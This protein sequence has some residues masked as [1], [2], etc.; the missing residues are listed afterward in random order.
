MAIG[1]C[2]SYGK[3][4]FHQS[5]TVDTENGAYTILTDDSTRYRQRGEGQVSFEEIKV[6]SKVIVLGQK[7]DQENTIQAKRVGIGAANN[8]DN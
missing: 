7:T 6:G 4:A 3:A 8:T 1:T 2:C 5:F